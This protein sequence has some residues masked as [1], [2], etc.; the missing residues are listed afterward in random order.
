M[1]EQTKKY[2]FI[3]I[4]IAW[5]LATLYETPGRVLFIFIPM[6][7]FAALHW[8]ILEKILKQR[9]SSSPLSQTRILGIY[10]I[11]ATITTLT[12]GLTGYLGLIKKI[13]FVGPGLFVLEFAIIT[14]LALM[15]FSRRLFAK[16]V[17]ETWKAILLAGIIAGASSFALSYG[18]WKIVGPYLPV[19]AS[20]IQITVPES[21]TPNS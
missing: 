17:K 4:F 12:F 10:G 6:F 8:Y 20:K 16:S 13:E 1:N 19:R 7:V 3:G 2:I 11:L 15:L 5:L 18:L 9:F 14:I 21:I